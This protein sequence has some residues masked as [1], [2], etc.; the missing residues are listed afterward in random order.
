MKIK[1]NEEHNKPFINPYNFIPAIW[2]QTERSDV[3][4]NEEK[5]ASD[6]CWNNQENPISDES[7]KGKEKLVSGILDCTLL[8]KT[9]LAVP[10]TDYTLELTNDAERKEDNKK[11]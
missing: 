2:T 4:A 5:A 8:T 6:E 1:Y 9:P 7:G 3:M 10:D 11:A